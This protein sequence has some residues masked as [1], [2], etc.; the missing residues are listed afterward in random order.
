MLINIK[1]Y[2]L[3]KL[4][5]IRR[6]LEFIDH[7]ALY[8]GYMTS[9]ELVKAAL[10]HKETERVP[11]CI[12]TTG[13]SNDEIRRSK[14]VTD[15]E[16]WLDN[17]IYQVY[18]PWWGWGNLAADW[19][20][21]DTPVSRANVKGFGSYHDTERAIKE[22]REK[23]DK[24]ILAMF[25]GSHFEKANFARGIENFLCDIAR[26]YDFAKKL[27]TMIIDKNMVMLENILGM[28]EI[29]GVLM[30]SDWGSQ[31]NLLMSPEV[32]QDLIRPGEQREYDLIHSYGKDVW[33]HSCGCID[34]LLPSLV[35]MGLDALNPVQPECMDIAKIKK[36][37]GD[38][39]TFWGGL[40]TQ[41]TL[42]FGTADQVRAEARH[43]RNMMSAGGGHIFAPA[44]AIQ[45]DVP[46]RNIE[47][48][49]EVAR[50]KRQSC[51]R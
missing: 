34:K 29:D 4:H 11:Y 26:D 24:Y 1:R 30:G 5:S 39:L 32:W 35:E 42:P 48:V 8:G 19:K 44:Q 21:F 38:K 12:M 15:P 43:V 36:L 3:I 16:E 18:P 2:H 25:Y 17:D 37:Y 7:T 47:V 41:Q 40:S 20:D 9:R 50:E 27:C 23:K 45:G 22:V 6:Y 28:P 46:L 13:E 14:G 51:Q 31:Q 10:A 33:V 49:L